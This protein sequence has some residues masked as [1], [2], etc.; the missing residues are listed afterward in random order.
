MIIPAISISRYL[1]IC[2]FFIRIIRFIRIHS[3]IS[4]IAIIIH[5][6]TNHALG[7]RHYFQNIFSFCQRLQARHPFHVRVITVFNP[8][9]Q[10]RCHCEARSN[11]IIVRYIRNSHQIKPRLLGNFLNFLQNIL[12]FHFSNLFYL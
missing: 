12:I 4:I 3:Y 2:I 1:P 11:L 8:F 6:N 9:I 10:L 5:R 7:I